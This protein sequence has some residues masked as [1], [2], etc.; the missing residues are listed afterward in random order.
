MFADR[1]MIGII[2][3]IACIREGFGNQL[4]MYACGYALAKERNTEFVID[5]TLLDNS[6][7]RRLE[8]LKTQVEFDQRISY[9]RK[10]DFISRALINKIRRRKHIGIGTKICKENDAWTYEPECFKEKKNVYLYGYW[11]SYR[12]FEKYDQKIK[13]MIVPRYNMPVKI[14]EKIREVQNEESVAVHVRRGDYVGI[15]CTLPLS[16]YKKAVVEMQDN[17]PEAKFYVFSDDIEL[18]KKEIGGELQNAVFWEDGSEEGSLNDFFLMSACRHQI[19]ANSTFS[20][21]AA[22]LNKNK[23]KKVYAPVFGNWTEK[24]YPPEW[25]KIN[26]QCII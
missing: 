21:W 24:F 22:Y 10:E 1:K 12:Y 11:Q 18:V 26:L 4:F 17:F 25:K 23:E 5:T 13:S 6:G 19:I 16:Y 9:G 2:M 3:V 7:Y 15:G 8:L 20:W 14:Q